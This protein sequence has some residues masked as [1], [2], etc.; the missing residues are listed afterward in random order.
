MNRTTKA[1]LLD[2]AEILHKAGWDQPEPAPSNSTVREAEAT[3]PSRLE[4]RDHLAPE[5]SEHEYTEAR[6][7]FLAALQELRNELSRRFPPMTQDQ[8]D[9]V[10]EEIR[11]IRQRISAQFGH[12]PAR[13]AAYCMEL[14]ERHRDRLIDRPE[15]PVRDDESSA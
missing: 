2:V 13:L 4:P 8:S 1:A 14:Q 7:E 6:L 15:S 9:P 5:T 12:D 3:H 10:V 11:E